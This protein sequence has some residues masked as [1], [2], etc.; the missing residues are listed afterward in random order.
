MYSTV[1][2][3]QEMGKILGKI[4]AFE[5]RAIEKKGSENKIQYETDESKFMY[6]WFSVTNITSNKSSKIIQERKEV[7]INHV[8]Q[9]KSAERNWREFLISQD[10]F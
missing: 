5:G 10:I 9:E 2:Q 8:R 6:H 7:I 3:N 1:N 4:P